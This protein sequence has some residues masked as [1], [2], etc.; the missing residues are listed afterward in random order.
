MYNCINIIIEN[1]AH[2]H[3]QCEQVVDLWIS[4]Q[5]LMDSQGDALSIICH[6]IKN[7][8]I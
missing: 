3:V 2:G 6:L 7:V 5:L 1:I 4:L 8:Q